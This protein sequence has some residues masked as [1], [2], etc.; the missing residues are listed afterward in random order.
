[1]ILNKMAAKELPWW[2]N[3]KSKPETRVV[4]KEKVCQLSWM[5]SA[6]SPGAWEEV[7]KMTGG[8]KRRAPSAAELVVAH[9]TEPES[10]F[11][12]EDEWRGATQ[13]HRRATST[14]QETRII[15]RTSPLVL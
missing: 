9:C 14:R 10:G 4:D 5:L 11:L 15:A 12:H 8:G 1:M 13:L 6:G 2:L 7:W 3:I